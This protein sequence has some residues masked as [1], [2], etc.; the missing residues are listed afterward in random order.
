[1]NS[2]QQITKYLLIVVAFVSISACA[3]KPKGTFEDST[4]TF[5]PDY[6]KGK[7][8]AALPSSQDN[9]DRTPKGMQDLQSEAKADVFYLH[10]TMYFG[11]R[12]YDQWN[13]PINLNKINQTVDEVPML[14][15]ATAFNA[16]GRVFAPRYR[17]A[18]IKSY[19]NKDTTSA[20]KAFD[21]AYADV[22]SAFKYYIDNYNNGRPIIIASHSQGTTHAKR[23]IKDIIDGKPL[24]NQLVV[25]YLIGIPVEMDDYKSIKA[26]QNKDETGCLVGWRTF[27]EGADPD[28]LDKES[29]ILITNPLSWTTDN[30]LAPKSMNQG[31]VLNDFD[32]EPTKGLVNAQIH[33]SI[34]WCN[35]PKFRGSFLLVSKN[36][37]KGDINLYYSNIRENAVHRVNQYLSK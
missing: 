6:S 34:L 1:M 22:K 13:A 26:C 24:Q 32:D 19:F 5:A 31:A 29:N 21:L 2:N 10:P 15:Q 28:F 30:T 11:D 4:S 37:H 18:H 14:F 3:S 35:K 23:L 20:R 25:A 33:K 12:D 7:Y 27:K 8:W 9:A 36:Y 16:A 17:Q